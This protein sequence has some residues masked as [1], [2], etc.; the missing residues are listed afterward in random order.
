MDERI[1]FSRSHPHAIAPTKGSRGAAGWDLYAAEECE[2]SAH[3]KARVNT[4]IRMSIPHGCYGRVAPRSGFSWNHHTD[5]GAGVIDSDFRGI[6]QVLLFNHKSDVL[7]IN[8]GDRI[9][10]L[11]IERIDTRELEEVDDLTSTQRGW[12]GFGSSG[13]R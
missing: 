11:V 12:H 1:Q 5:V 8:K 9:A 7:R 4:G 10:Q 3:G 6:I 2:L 13:Q